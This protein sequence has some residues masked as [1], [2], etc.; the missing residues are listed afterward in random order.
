MAQESTDDIS[1]ITTGKYYFLKGRFKAGS[2]NLYGLFL[3]IFN[4]EKAMESSHAAVSTFSTI[5]ELEPH[6]EWQV[7]EEKITEVRWKGNC[8]MNMTSAV[9]S[10]FDSLNKDLSARDEIYG[11]VSSY[12]YSLLDVALSDIINRVIRDKALILETGIQ[13]ALPEEVVA[14]RDAH[15]KKQT[16][17]TKPST[18]SPTHAFRVDDGSSIVPAS[19]VL[20]PVKGKLL[21][22]LKIG[23][24]IMLR[25]NHKTDI[26]AFY[27]NLYKLKTPDGK[28]KSIPGEVI[29]IKSESKDLPVSILARIDNQLFAVATEED[30]HVRVYLYDPKT[31]GSFKTNP[32]GTAPRIKTQGHHTSAA[33]KNDHSP[34]VFLL[35]GFAAFLVMVLL[36]IIYIYI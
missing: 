6:T 26:G 15:L 16:D 18:E 25:F 5:Y 24:M 11:M 4:Q 35:L 19:M 3:I 36:L 12:N 21:Y 34:A 14:A 30:R 20:S 7:F 22:E 2:S 23:D 32:S 29:D 33:V 10:L 13:E 27:I 17:K 8:N 31:D 28:Y 9:V 1:S